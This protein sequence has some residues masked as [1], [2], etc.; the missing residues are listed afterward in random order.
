MAVAALVPEQGVG[1]LAELREARPSLRGRAGGG[2][3]GNRRVEPLRLG[4]CGGCGREICREEK[5]E[6]EDTDKGE[7]REKRDRKS[8]V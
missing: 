5:R 7:G 6:G 8:V 4:F 3:G 1:L 2:G